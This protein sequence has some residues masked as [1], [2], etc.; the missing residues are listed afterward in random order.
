MTDNLYH[1]NNTVRYT[2]HDTFLY[3]SLNL[4]M[5]KGPRSSVGSAFDLQSRGPG[6][7]PGFGAYIRH[8]IHKTK[9]TDD[10]DYDILN[11]LKTVN[12]YNIY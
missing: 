12:T 2:V 8:D 6:I 9:A 1:H 5:P 4:I 7:D 3:T 10:H 11:T